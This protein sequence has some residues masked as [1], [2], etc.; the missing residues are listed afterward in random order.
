MVAGVRE[1][2]RGQFYLRMCFSLLPFATTAVSSAGYDD[3][4]HSKSSESATNRIDLLPL[5][6]PLPLL[7]LL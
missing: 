7:L 4:H 3:A 6:L 1:C 2:R 5:P